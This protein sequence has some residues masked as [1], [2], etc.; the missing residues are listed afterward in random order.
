M[1]DNG[2]ARLDEIARRAASEQRDLTRRERR[3]VRALAGPLPTHSAPR[4]ALVARALAA[5]QERGQVVLKVRCGACANQGQ[6][7]GEVRRS[8]AGFVFDATLAGSIGWAPGEKEQALADA[9]DWGP[10]R[11]PIPGEVGRCIVL[12]EHGADQDAPAVE[13]PRCGSIGLDRATLLARGRAHRTGSAATYVAQPP[14]S[15]DR[16]GDASG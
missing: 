7:L 1:N 6:S 14:P 12:L 9:H 2:V 8:S 15:I 16:T 3:E 4:S 13:C 5:A 11:L 10:G